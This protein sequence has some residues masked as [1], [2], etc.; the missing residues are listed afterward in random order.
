MA[1]LMQVQCDGCGEY[2]TVPASSASWVWCQDCR[3]DVEEVD[4]DRE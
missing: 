1:T 4:Y 2:V 3:E